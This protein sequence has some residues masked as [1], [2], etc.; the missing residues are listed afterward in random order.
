MTLASEAAVLAADDPVKAISVFQD[1][2]EEIRRVIYYRPKKP[3]PFPPRVTKRSS[4]KWAC[5]KTKKVAASA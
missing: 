5:S 4:N 2:L 1:V 3:R